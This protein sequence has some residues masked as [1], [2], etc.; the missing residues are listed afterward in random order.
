MTSSLSFLNSK[1][2][3]SRIFSLSI[4]LYNFDRSVF[5]AAE[6]I[7]EIFKT[8]NTNKRI[9]GKITFKKLSIPIPGRVL[10]W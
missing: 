9:S 10:T 7:I 1:T 6:I 3:S 5:I 8:K 4:H 2:T